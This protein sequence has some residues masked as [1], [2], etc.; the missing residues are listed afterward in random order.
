MID[1]KEL[2]IGNYIYNF[3]SGSPELAEL[4]G[5]DAEGYLMLQNKEDKYNSFCDEDIQ[6]IPITEDILVKC[7][8]EVIE[9]GSEYGTLFGYKVSK[10][11]HFILK[12][13]TLHPNCFVEY[14]FQQPIKTLHQLQN[15]IMDLCGQELNIQ[16]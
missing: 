5:V 10:F 1:P 6:P 7:G 4:I 12:Q 14:N 16:L 9:I 8:F 13:N 11:R 2:R 15:V 3:S